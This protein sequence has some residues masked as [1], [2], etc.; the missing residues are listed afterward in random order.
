MTIPWAESGQTEREY[1]TRYVHHITT[2][3]GAVRVEVPGLTNL[4]AHPAAG[5]VEHKLTRGFRV[6]GP[7]PTPRAVVA[8]AC[9]RSALASPEVQPP[10]HV[11][12]GN[13]HA[14]MSGVL[15]EGDDVRHPFDDSAVSA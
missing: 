9:R 5:G 8:P 4:R 7:E 13:P 14:L 2:S 12:F 15:R 11:C 3:S 1:A 10:L 6:R